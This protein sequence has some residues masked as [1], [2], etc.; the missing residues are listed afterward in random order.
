MSSLPPTLEAFFTSRL[1][2]QRQVTPHTLTAYRDGF[3][4][5]LEF[6]HGRTGKM[7]ADLDIEDLDARMVADFLQHLEV[8]R[9]NSVRTRNARLAALRSFYR[10]ASF[11]HPEHAELIQRVLSIPQKR[12]DHTLLSFLSEVEIDALLAAPDR[13]TG[14]G[15]RDY[16]LLLLDLQTGLRVS[17][18]TGLTGKDVMLGAGAHVY[19]RGKGRKDRITPLRPQT[20]AVLKVWLQERRGGPDSPLFPGRRDRPLSTD[21]VASL[22][23]KY[24]SRAWESCPSLVGK[25]VSPHTLRHTCA[26]RLLHAGVDIATIALWLGHEG[27]ETTQGYLHADLALKQRALARTAPDRVSPGRYHPKDAVLAFLEGL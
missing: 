3:R 15:R 27:I 14:I 24:V 16:A 10:F 6:V 18:L 9:R 5:L 1:I 22:V 8:D 20:V 2:Q 4:L 12:A 23:S 26:M 25:Q 11:R 19:C 7:P 21:A 13:S 17:E